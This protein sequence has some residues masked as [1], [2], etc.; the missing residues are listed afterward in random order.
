MKCRYV[1][2]SNQM[3]RTRD[4]DRMCETDKEHEW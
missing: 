1:Y 3:D 2:H 4:S